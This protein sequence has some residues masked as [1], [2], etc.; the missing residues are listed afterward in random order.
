LK[1]VS[2][3]IQ[4]QFN[5][6]TLDLDLRANENNT[7]TGINTF[8]ANTFFEGEKTQLTG[9]VQVGKDLRTDGSLN[10]LGN[11]IIGG[12]IAINGDAEI[13]GNLKISNKVSS[14]TGNVNLDGEL[15]RFGNLISDEDP[16]GAFN[17]SRYHYYEQTTQSNLVIK[18]DFDCFGE[19]V[20]NYYF[21]LS[22]DDNTLEWNNIENA[23]KSFDFWSVLTTSGESYFYTTESQQ[24]YGYLHTEETRKGGQISCMKIEPTT[25]MI[26]RPELRVIFKDVV[27]GTA[28]EYT[29]AR[30]EKVINLVNDENNDIDLD[31][32][33]T[34]DLT[35]SGDIN[36]SS[37]LSVIGNITTFSQLNVQDNI[38][39]N[40]SITSKDISANGPLNVTGNIT[41]GGSLSIA[42]NITGGGSL[43]AASANIA[44]SIEAQSLKVNTINVEFLNF[45][46]ENTDGVTSIRSEAS[47]AEYRKNTP[48]YG[49][50]G[51]LSRHDNG[52]DTTAFVFI[53]E[54]NIDDSGVFFIGHVF[55]KVILMMSKKLKKEI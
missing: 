14:F 55:A 34:K 13:G 51:I 44:T 30:L 29:G 20:K 12:N 54:S 43:S 10:V 32:V 36:A 19:V 41:G 24:I 31:N 1:D 11:A 47:F 5:E 49:S 53:S 50:S 3:N 25:S 48:G 9:N 15:T 2:A 23:H 37:N 28:N 38:L 8:Q 17:T 7:F 26:L 33:T 45:I 21:S 52:S 16:G 39:T 6:I 27:S 22:G 46:T 18:N 4:E 42:N 40:G 35:V